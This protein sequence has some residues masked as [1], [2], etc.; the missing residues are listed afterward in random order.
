MFSLLQCLLQ[1]ITFITIPLFYLIFQCILN[2]QSPV[3]CAPIT[4]SDAA[5]AAAEAENETDLDVVIAAAEAE[6]ETD[7][8][9]AAAEADNESDV[10]NFS[11]PGSAA[12][13]TRVCLPVPMIPPPGM[14]LVSPTAAA[15][16]RPLVPPTAAAFLRKT[17]S[18][19]R[20]RW[21][22]D[23]KTNNMCVPSTDGLS[24]LCIHCVGKGKHK[25][26]INMRRPFAPGAFHDHCTGR[27]HCE[28]VKH[29]EAEKKKKELKHKEQKPMVHFFAVVKKKKGREK[30]SE[31]EPDSNAPSDGAVTTGRAVSVVDLTTVEPPSIT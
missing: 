20:N 5:I 6:K 1:C 2:K 16:S 27:K 28:S 12:H 26:V 18:D 7:A 8:A 10:M 17:R 15:V 3:D 24:I 4:D 30:P 25:G 21:D 29:K 23:V 13:P 14:P 9:I 19:G 22:D 31:K 11:L